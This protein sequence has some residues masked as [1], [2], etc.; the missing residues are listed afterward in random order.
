MH[1]HEMKFQKKL[2]PKKLFPINRSELGNKPYKKGL[3]ITG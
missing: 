1:F 2:F 3:G